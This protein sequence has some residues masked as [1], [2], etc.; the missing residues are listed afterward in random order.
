MKR[1][2]WNQW[3]VLGLIGGVLILALLAV[4]V[5]VNVFAPGTPDAAPEDGSDQGTS[6]GVSENLDQFGMLTPPVTQ[7]PAVF[8]P[9]A[10]QALFTY[11]TRIAD[12]REASGGI[13]AWL[14]DFDAEP[15][16]AHPLGFDDAEQTIRFSPFPDDEAYRGQ[17]ERETKVTAVVLDVKMDDEHRDWDPGFEFNQYHVVT[18]DLEVTYEFTNDDGSR[19]ELVENTTVSVELRCGTGEAIP[20]PTEN[21]V[22]WKYPEEFWI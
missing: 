18:V 10:A 12:Y 16:L 20:R 5:L 22:V 7:D 3:R 15:F 17:S 6:E 13:A 1:M 19:R 4:V 14:Q 9:L 21:C 8:G 11:D 2:T